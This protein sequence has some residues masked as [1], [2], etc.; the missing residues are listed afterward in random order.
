M[1]TLAVRT[2]N[3]IL[4]F[5]YVIVVWGVCG[6]PR[7]YSYC[8]RNVSCRTVKSLGRLGA[9][10]GPNRGELFRRHVGA[11]AKLRRHHHATFAAW[12]RLTGAAGRGW[13]DVIVAATAVAAAAA[14]G[15]SAAAHGICCCQRLCNSRL[16]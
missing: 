6:G 1:R 2:D 10:R 11:A 8:I 7:A 13:R 3:N 16:C 9:L 4:W 5:V 15:T 14:S 12:R